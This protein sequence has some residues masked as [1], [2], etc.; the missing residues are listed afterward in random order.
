MANMSL[1]QGTDSWQSSSIFPAN[2]TPCDPRFLSLSVAAFPGSQALRLESGLPYSMTVQ[3]LAEVSSEPSVPTAEHGPLPVVNF[4][5]LGVIRCKAC[6]AY[7]NPFCKFINGGSSWRCCLCG[8]SNDV[9]SGYFCDLDAHG[10]RLDKVNRAELCSSSIEIVA[11]A[12]YMVRPP[13][14]PV[15]VFAIDVSQRSIRTG[16]L[17]SVCNTVYG[18]LD[19]LVTIPRTKVA[20][21]TFDSHIHLYSL[22]PKLSRPQMMVLPNLE[23]LFLPFPD[24][25]LVNLEESRPLVEHLLQSLPSMHADTQDVESSLGAAVIAAH[26][27]ANA[28]G[29]KVLFFSTAL[30]SFGPARLRNRETGASSSN[31]VA[32]LKPAMDFYKTWGIKYARVQLRADMFL[33]PDKYCDVATTIALCQ[34]SGGRVFSFSNFDQHRSGECLRSDL[35]RVLTCEQSWE[36]V[37]RVRVSK[38]SK[39][40]GYEGNFF[41]RGTDLLSVPNCTADDSFVVELAHEETPPHG[42]IIIQVA[43][44]YTASYGERRIR[45]HNHMIPVVDKLEDL[46]YYVDLHA[47]VN[48]IAKK[49]LTPS[50]ESSLAKGRQ[51]IETACKDI[52]IAY[53]KSIR[54]YNV[55]LAR[56]EE[57]PDTL[58]YLPMMTLCLLKCPAF[59]DSSSMS[60]DE[61][62]IALANVRSMN[63]QSLDTYLRPR[64]YPVHQLHAQEGLPDASG[65]V[66]LPVEINATAAE[67]SFDGAYLADN[68]LTI[69]LWIGRS[70]SPHFLQECFGMTTVF[71]APPDSIEL[72][73]ITASSGRDGVLSRLHNIIDFLRSQSVTCQQLR[74]VCQPSDDPSRK[75]RPACVQEFFDCLILDRTD[76]VMSYSEFLT[77]LS[78]STS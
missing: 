2:V 59:K 22:R 48:C 53:R 12:E 72:M 39:I 69:F 51:L 64:I 46:F 35:S 32:L 5:S 38:G 26:R 11:P 47:L 44:L 3:P 20:F 23:D 9:T 42:A 19:F 52:L 4:E 16:V 43:L 36:A 63:C 58:R 8:R 54:N 10:D 74:I 34:L 75:H 29:G 21:I 55:S 28:I 68:G 13:Q 24:D 27:V 15:F 33:F 73:P 67:L 76:T 45:V 57:Y 77:S 14:C 61:R 6:R 71:S 17:D 49:A 18:L 65:I 30:P 1:Q 66:T 25:Y 37:M 70:I 7:I 31:E 56:E 62:S 40:V 41:L 78:K 60:S 50:L